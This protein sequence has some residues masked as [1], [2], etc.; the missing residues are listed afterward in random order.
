MSKIL[1]SEIRVG[2][3][4]EWET[5][6]WKVA[7]CY[8]VHVGGRGGAYMQ[9][10]MK[11]IERDIKVNQRFMTD[12]KVERTFM[13]RIQ[14]EY[15]YNDGQNFIF[16]DNS[17]FEQHSI[18]NSF[19][20]EQAGY[21]LPNTIVGINFHNE[22]PVGL[23]LPQTVILE[24]VEVDS[25]IKD[26]TV[27]TSF[28]PVILETGLQIMVPPFVNKGEKVKVHTDTGEYMERA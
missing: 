13:D 26:S 18:P 6:L 28:K 19:L 14:A 10:E 9:V 1:A 21:L 2:Q 17:I 15:L 11:D 27:A 16:M 12:E 3:L 20:E 22:R 23:E 4:L 25:S 7:K 24:V 8:H 5:H